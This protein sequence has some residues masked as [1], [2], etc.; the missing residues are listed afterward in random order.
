[1]ERREWFISS[2]SRWLQRKKQSTLC[3]R[4][5]NDEGVWYATL[6]DVTIPEA[7]SDDRMPSCQWS[8][9][10]NSRIN[11]WADDPTDFSATN[12]HH[13]YASAWRSQTPRRI[14]LVIFS[15]LTPFL[16]LRN[17]TTCIGCDKPST[18]EHIWLNCWHFIGTRLE[19]HFTAQS[20]RL[21][22]E[23]ISVEKILNYLKAINIFGR[24]WT[25]RLFWLC[26][27]FNH[28][29]SLFL[30][31]VQIPVLARTHF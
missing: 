10:V 14:T 24:I 25:F 28:F 15:S 7:T 16:T 6:S 26:I 30:K 1:M 3:C 19:S 2:F 17:M 8:M 31:S 21:L 5:A 11:Y 18:I 12:R 9:H 4:A 29:L 13:R 27:W 20:L 23:E 22:F